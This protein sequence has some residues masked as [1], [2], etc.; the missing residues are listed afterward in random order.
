MVLPP[1]FVSGF[2]DETQIKKMKYNVF[3]RTGL[4][5]SH[6]S[7]GTGGFCL[8]Y[9]DYSIQQCKETLHKAIKAGINFID[10]A[11]WYGHGV[12]EEVLGKCL[13]GIPRRAYY[14]AT[15]VG[16]YE[17]DPKLMFNFSAD[18]TRESIDTSLK[19]LG[20]D[21]IDL[22]QAHDIEFAKSLDI[23]I[24]ETLPVLNESVKNGK[25]KY[26]GITGYPVSTLSKCLNNSK[27]PIDSVLSY[28]R[29]SLLNSTLNEYLSDFRL[30]NLGIVN[31]AGH[32]MGL[33]TNT[34]PQPWHPAPQSIKDICKEARVYCQCYRCANRT[35]TKRK[36]QV[37]P[38]Q[39]IF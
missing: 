8:Q 35:C 39:A 28:S 38:S 36:I 24:D 15:K 34:G 5:I 27:I 4:V 7:L 10:T 12:S 13:E 18:K 23:I 33:L 16:R 22:I 29:L 6:L 25:A 14:I 3:G 2:H 26:I 30:K 1:T 11:P 19:R 21:Y 20:I 31:A 9:G 37:Q 32:C 17:A